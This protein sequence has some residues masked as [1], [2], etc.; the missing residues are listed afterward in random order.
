MTSTTL[1]NELIDRIVDFLHN[2]VKSLRACSLTSRTFR[3]SAIPRLFACLTLE[4]AH[5]LKDMEFFIH[6]A[7]L[8]RTI[9]IHWWKASPHYNPLPVLSQPLNPGGESPLI[10]LTTVIHEYIT[11]ASQERRTVEFLSLLIP[12]GG[13]N[14]LTEL[15][16]RSCR[17]PSL[18]AL[19]IVLDSCTMLKKLTVWTIFLDDFNKVE[20]ESHQ[21]RSRHLRTITL[22]GLEGELGSF[23]AWLA[24]RAV[25]PPL[26]DV[27][28][29]HDYYEVD[30]LVSNIRRFNPDCVVRTSGNVVGGY[31]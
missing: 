22:G 13:A 20:A 7:L 2:D 23:V 5:P 24:S 28:V 19:T 1:P 26:D 3:H 25:L 21:I 4:A 29:P 27:V 18:A 15:H 12:R 31:L 14:S 30:G 11:Y 6:I 8:V 16:F 17:F 10:N 9:R